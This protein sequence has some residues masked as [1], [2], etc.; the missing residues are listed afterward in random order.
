MPEGDHSCSPDVTVEAINGLK[1]VSG[2]SR[3]R[4]RRLRGGGSRGKGGSMLCTGGSTP[5]YAQMTSLM[6]LVYGVRHGKGR[7]WGGEQRWLMSLRPTR[8]LYGPNLIAHLTLTSISLETS[9]FP[10]PLV[11]AR[12]VIS[13][14]SFTTGI[15]LSCLSP[16]SKIDLCFFRLGLW[17]FF[18][19]RTRARNRTCVVWVTQYNVLHRYAK[20][21]RYLPS[22]HWES[23]FMP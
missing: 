18:F 12:P 7:M 1:V 8:P 15:Q 2:G 23:N 9:F 3:G 13:L 21:A 5:R 20:I 6:D 14:F 11:T 10:A 19:L 16:L 22:Q 4:N 17:F